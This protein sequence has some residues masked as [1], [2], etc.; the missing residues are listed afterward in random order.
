[1]ANGGYRSNLGGENCLADLCTDEL[2]GGTQ[3][4][5]PLKKNAIKKKKERTASGFRKH[6]EGYVGKGDLLLI[7]KKK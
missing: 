5:G 1:V 2:T 6:T 7:E 4:L 3:E